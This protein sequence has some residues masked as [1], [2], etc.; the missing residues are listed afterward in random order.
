MNTSDNNNGTTINYNLKKWQIKGL[1]L[2]ISNVFIIYIL[3]QTYGFHQ[4]RMGILQEPNNLAELSKMK[5]N[6]LE[7]DVD[8]PYHFYKHELHASI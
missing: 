1:K 5:S 8:D 6:D 2:Y 4:S 3:Q 7:A